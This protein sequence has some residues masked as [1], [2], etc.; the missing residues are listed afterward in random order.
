MLTLTLDTNTL[1][2]VFEENTGTR[3]Y[4]KQV[5]KLL[6][7]AKSG[8][9][10]LAVTTVFDRD[11]AADPNKSRLAGLRAWVPTLPLVAD[12]P[13]VARY[14]YSSFGGGDVYGSMDDAIR[15]DQ[16]AA[17]VFPR[18]ADLSPSS[19]RNTR[20]QV[21]DVDHLAA[22]LRAH[23]DSFVTGDTGI[24]SKSKRLMNEFDI[25]VWTPDQALNEV[26]RTSRGESDGN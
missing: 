21:N 23:R 16:L 18:L 13:A 20:S 15:L 8:E 2:D 10:D 9:V 24:L 26:Q 7:L 6:E 5:R 1:K 4:A 19:H 25:R 17:L 11:A 3:K 12:L 22:H 14:D